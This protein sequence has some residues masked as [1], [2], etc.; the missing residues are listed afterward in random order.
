M[1][2]LPGDLVHNH[3]NTIKV[4]KPSVNPEWRVAW[5]GSGPTDKT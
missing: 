3:E 4:V 5:L 1:M 2:W